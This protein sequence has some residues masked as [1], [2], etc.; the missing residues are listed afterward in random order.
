[1]PAYA[2]PEEAVAAFLQLVDYRRNQAALMEAPP[3]A[4]SDSAPDIDAAREVM[5]AALGAGPRDA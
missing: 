4:P 1:M 2:T 3:S 5:R